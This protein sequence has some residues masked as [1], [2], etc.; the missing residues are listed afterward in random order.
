MSIW[1]AGSS[2]KI[3]AAVKMARCPKCGKTVEV[4]ER[5]HIKP[6]VQSKIFEVPGA[7]K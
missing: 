6:H 4:T 3:Y 2:E 7:K 1:C 5:K